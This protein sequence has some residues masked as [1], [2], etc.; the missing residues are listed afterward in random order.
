[1]KACRITLSLALLE[2]AIS[3][4]DGHKIL[5]FVPQTAE[6]IVN[7]TSEVVVEGPSLPEHRE[8]GPL[9]RMTLAQHEDGA[10]TI[11]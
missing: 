5:N 6:D 2:R 4:P 10:T 11:E 3:L 8:G 9:M 1:M 7:R